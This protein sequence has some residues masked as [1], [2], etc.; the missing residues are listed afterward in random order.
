M[1][2]AFWVVS[3]ERHELLEQSYGPC[4]SGMVF[5]V[6]IDSCGPDRSLLGGLCVGGHCD[7]AN[8]DVAESS[9]TT[10]M[11]SRNPH[12]TFVCYGGSTLIVS[13]YVQIQVA[14]AVAETGTYVSTNWLQPA[15]WYRRIAF[16][17]EAEPA[18][19]DTPEVSS[20]STCRP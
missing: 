12:G 19:S 6:E 11:I 13:R 2:N 1:L 10:G 3:M 5:S 9:G 7:H 20:S 16:A 8:R 14:R 17:G 15:G 18:Y 4:E